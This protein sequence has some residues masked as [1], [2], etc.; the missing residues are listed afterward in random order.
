MPPHSAPQE[1]DYNAVQAY[2][3]Q[4]T[5]T[6]SDVEHIRMRP[7]I[8]VGDV[9]TRG[10]HHLLDGL[11]RNSLDEFRA[12]FG[13]S[14]EVELLSDG[15]CRV[16]DG[17]RGIPVGWT[18]NEQPTTLEILFTTKSCRPKRG[19]HWVPALM[20]VNALADRLEVAVER[21]GKLW[22]AEFQRGELSDEARLIRN[23][24][25]TGTTLTFWPDPY[26]F[27][28]RPRF[29]FN[30]LADRFRELAALHPGLVFTLT[31][32]RGETPR[33]ETFHSPGGVSD[34]VRFLNRL[35]QPVHPEV[36]SC[37]AE[38]DGQECRVAFQWTASRDER[39][40]S[41]AN[42]YF[43]FRGG[44]HLSGFRSAV[45]RT[46]FDYARS[47]GLVDAREFPTGEDCLNGVTA[48]VALQLAEPQFCSAVRERLNNL[49]AD[50]LVRSAVAPQLAAYLERHP[51]D[52]RA[53]WARVLDARDAR[54]IASLL[55]RKK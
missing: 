17:A 16:R 44:P 10:L 5:Q 20:A 29:D 45:T 39:L 21:D 1:P 50:G 30:F 55:H 4:N 34:F 43:T 24:A 42:G 40:R 28:S 7:G 12:G 32:R 2:T 48:I 11:V 52:A 41:Y 13:T 25:R 38:G 19:L 18:S 51:D 36:I 54:V 3:A 22:Q 6:Y 23:A 15:G 31:D 33:S 47:S 53:I 37:R 35:E 49:E 14:I 27:W 9:G 26:V 46:V 8:Y